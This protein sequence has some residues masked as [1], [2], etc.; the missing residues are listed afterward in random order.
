MLAVLFA[1]CPALSFANLDIALSVDKAEVRQNEEAT[2]TVRVSNRGSAEAADVQVAGTLPKGVL[3]LSCNAANVAAHERSLL[4]KTPDLLPGEEYSFDV[5]VRMERK[6]SVENVFQLQQKGAALKNASVAVNVLSN[7]VLKIEVTMFTPNGDGIN[8][9]FEIPGL[10]SYPNNEIVIFNRFSDR[11][12]Q[13]RGY[14]ND[15]DAAGL[16]NGNYFYVLTLH[17]SN[18]TVQKYNGHIAVKR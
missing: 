14:A 4:V 13:K 5:V 11:V 10:H 18:G 6:G 9:Y 3:F 17:L 15:W 16:P 1:L 2:F 8:D 12:Y 7:N